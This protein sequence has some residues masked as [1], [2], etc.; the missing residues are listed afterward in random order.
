M[1]STDIFPVRTKDMRCTNENVRILAAIVSFIGRH[2]QRGKEAPSEERQHLL[3][4]IC[5]LYFKEAPKEEPI[6]HNPWGRPHWLLQNTEPNY[7]TGFGDYT[8]ILKILD[9]GVVTKPVM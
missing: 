1:S 3:R 4:S 5:L 2:Q 8:E 6:S 7:I 9:L